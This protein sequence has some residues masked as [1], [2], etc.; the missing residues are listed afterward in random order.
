MRILFD[1][2]TPVHIA[3]SLTSHTVRTAR[4]QGWSSLS[5]GD[6]LRAAEAAGFDVL[7]TTDRN[8]VYQQNLKARKIA[9]VVLSKNRWILMQPKLPQIVAAVESTRPGSYAEV[10]IPER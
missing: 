9:I 5:N 4:Q 10:E 7:L 1:Q 8:L 2:G 3:R 6:L